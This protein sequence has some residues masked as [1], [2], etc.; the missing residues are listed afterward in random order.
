MTKIG[1][2]K[3]NIFTT[4]QSFKLLSLCYLFSSFKNECNIDCS[5]D[6]NTLKSIATQIL[7]TE[8]PSINLLA[9][10]IIK[11]L[12]TNKN[13]PK[14]TM[15]IGKVKITKIGFTIRFKID[16]T[17]ATKIAVT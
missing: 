1:L 7:L 9:N 2:Q 8:K 5:M 6:N 12:M 14:V 10:K 13:N 11:A 15:V 3:Y 17:T 4:L 16:S